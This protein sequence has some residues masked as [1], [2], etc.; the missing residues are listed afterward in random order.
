M[1][2]P[3]NLDPSGNL[4]PPI[5]EYD[6][7][8]GCSVTGGYVFRGGLA[9]ARGRYF[10]GDYCTATIWSFVVRDGRATDVRTHRFEVPDAAI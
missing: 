6:H 4:V 5:Y 8:L 3:E 2:E 9:S 1:F 7:D 10:F